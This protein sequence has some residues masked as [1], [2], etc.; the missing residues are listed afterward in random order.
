MPF[1]DTKWVGLN[2]AYA[3]RSVSDIELSQFPF[4]H[5]FSKWLNANEIDFD[6]ERNVVEE[7]NQKRKS[8]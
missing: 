1:K 7:W 2:G 4:F 5:S 8:I 6:G 3:F